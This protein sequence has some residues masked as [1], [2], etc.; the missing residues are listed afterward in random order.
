VDTLDPEIKKIVNEQLNIL[1]DRTANKWKSSF[2]EDV[3]NAGQTQKG[4]FGEAI[5]ERLLNNIGIPAEIINGGKGEFDI[6]IKDN[7]A[8]VLI[9]HK[10]ATEDVNNFFQF[11]GI[12]KDV[13]Y[14]YVFCLGV[15]PDKLWFN[16]FPKSVCDELTTS[17]TKG[18]S[19]SYK[20]TA[21]PFS[22]GTYTLL[23]LTEENFKREVKKIV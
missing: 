9:E 14:D 22:S 15:S 5:T 13:H 10:L 2:F 23:P 20:L 7:K 18:G 8:D 19:D 6:L 4:D 1:R 16:I 3:K 17:M 21:K 12:K 11:N